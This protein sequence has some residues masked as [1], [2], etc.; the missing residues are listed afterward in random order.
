[1]GCP[2]SE[3]AEIR[4]SAS[5]T[6]SN[7]SFCHNAPIIIDEKLINLTSRFR[8]QLLI[9]YSTV[10]GVRDMNVPNSLSRA[11]IQ[12]VTLNL[13]LLISNTVLTLSE[14]IFM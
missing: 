1:M 13:D 9:V 2:G 3:G 12:Y 8:R 14:V 7:Y 4:K 10:Q 5:H 11:T 6:M